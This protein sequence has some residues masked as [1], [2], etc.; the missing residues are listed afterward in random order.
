[1][2]LDDPIETILKLSTACPPE[3]LW[4]LDLLEPEEA[5]ELAMTMASAMLLE[6][7]DPPVTEVVVRLG[8]AAE[9]VQFLRVEITL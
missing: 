7:G 2:N 9:W 3:A 1:M 4:W 8:G 5:K 6:L